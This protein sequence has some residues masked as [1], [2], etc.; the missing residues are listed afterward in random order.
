MSATSGLDLP[1]RTG[2][3][4]V[5]TLRT[6]LS[7][8]SSVRPVEHILALRS[9]TTLTVL[10][11]RGAISEAEIAAAQTFAQARGFDLVHFPGMETAEANR[12]IQLAEPVYH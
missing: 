12:R 8:E 10:V 1:P 3:K 6:A 2:F 5:S 7:L 9:I 11:K 4:L